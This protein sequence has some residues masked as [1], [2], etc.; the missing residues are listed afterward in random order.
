MVSKNEYLVSSSTLGEVLIINLSSV[1]STLIQV[2]S[3]PSRCL[4]NL[5]STRDWLLLTHVRAAI[6][7]KVRNILVDLGSQN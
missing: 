5:N 2:G 3:D 1:S 4:D 6:D 7:L